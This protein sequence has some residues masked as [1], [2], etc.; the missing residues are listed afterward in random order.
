[1]RRPV[2]RGVNDAER[3]GRRRD[4]WEDRAPPF[5]PPEDRHPMAQQPS[6]PTIGKTVKTGHM[7]ICIATTAKTATVLS[8]RRPLSRVSLK[9]LRTSRVRSCLR[10]VDAGS[11]SPLALMKIR[12]ALR[13]NHRIALVAAQ[14]V[15]RASKPCPLVHITSPSPSMPIA[16][17]RNLLL[18]EPLVRPRPD[19]RRIDRPSSSARK[20]CARPCWRAPPR[21]A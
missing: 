1:M 11:R 7:H 15:Q 10:P 12:L 20:R 4:D 6:K 18:E 13:P 8:G 21:S 17:R 5:A 14:T 3:T 19:G 2:P 9:L 16:L